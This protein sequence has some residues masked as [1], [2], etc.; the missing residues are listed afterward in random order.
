MRCTLSKLS[1]ESLKTLPKSFMA[2]SL[3]AAG[4]RWNMPVSPI[5]PQRVKST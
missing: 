1:Q 4:V 5:S 2:S 3:L